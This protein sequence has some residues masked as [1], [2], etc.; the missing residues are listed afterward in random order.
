MGNDPK[1]LTGY[2]QVCVGLNLSCQ[3][4]GEALEHPRVVGQEAVDLQAA[5]HQDPIS[6]H[7]HRVDGQS[8]LVPYDVWLRHSCRATEGELTLTVSQ[9]KSLQFKKIASLFV[10]YSQYS[11]RDYLIYSD[12]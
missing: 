9:V 6:G 7:L 8:V 10:E 2:S 12:I 1:A 3:V 5:P 11:N 4:S